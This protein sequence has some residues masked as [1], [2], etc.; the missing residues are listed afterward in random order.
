VKAAAV[1]SLPNHIRANLERRSYM[2]SV[3][4]PMK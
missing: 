4:D 1:S 2:L 3:R